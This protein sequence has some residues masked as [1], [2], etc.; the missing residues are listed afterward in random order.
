MKI[1]K[2]LV[3]SF[4]YPPDI[5]A[6]SFRCAALIE[7]L[8]Q[9][10]PLEAEIH[11]LATMPNRFASFTIPALT[12]EHQGKI[13][14]HRLPLLSHKGGTIAQVR[15]FL[16]YALKT[17]RFVKANKYDLVLATSAKL[18][19]ATLG[20]WVARQQKSKL[21]LDI[22]DIFVDTIEDVLIPKFATL[23]IPW[24]SLIEKWTIKKA[25]RVNLVS[26]GFAK[27]F[28]KRYPNAAFSF[29][30][31]GIDEEFINLLPTSANHRPQT[32]INK[33]TTATEKGRPANY[34]TNRKIKLNVVY[35][36]TIGEGQGL[37]L[38]IP[39]LAN[40]LREQLQFRIIGDGP[41]KNKLL[42]ALTNTCCTN[43]ELINPMQRS[44]LS[45]EY[46]NADILFLHLNEHKAFHKVLPSKLF[47]YAATGKPIW[48]GVA[49][50][51]A[52]F[53]HDEI[54]NAV[55]FKPKDT[56][57]AINVLSLLTL[58]TTIRNELII[59]YSRA[60]I[61]SAMAREICNLT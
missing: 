8:Q 9:I 24:L 21:Y 34:F 10:L 5:S 35:A 51:A 52:K 14:I 22:R 1:L 27:Y 54:S 23:I 38:I 31:N 44:A 12:I 33:T 25:N 30:T 43:V 37:D 19:T 36:G 56:L 17:H 50:F 13:I 42:T 46:R 4:Y 6:G 59:K 57:Q 61:M 7:H 29:Y 20:A 49:G 40:E 3:L 41:R 45:E 16:R 39:K 18:F 60:K 15:N 55:T 47:E 2:I 53:I 11:V 48:A 26:P 32:T 58:Q 28:K